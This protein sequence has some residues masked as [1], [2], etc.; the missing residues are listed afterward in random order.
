M[1]LEYYRRQCSDERTIPGL[2]Q[3][4][5]RELQILTVHVCIQLVL[6]EVLQLIARQG[7]GYL[8]VQVI[9][10]VGRFYQTH[11]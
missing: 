4:Y 10:L 9:E 2:F 7:Q 6:L 3:A 11:P 8:L 1:M 5:V